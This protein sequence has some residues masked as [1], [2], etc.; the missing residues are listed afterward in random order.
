MPPQV[1]TPRL[2][3]LI[4]TLLAIKLFLVKLMPYVLRQI[5]NHVTPS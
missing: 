3:L 2:Q 1:A 4:I 5:Y